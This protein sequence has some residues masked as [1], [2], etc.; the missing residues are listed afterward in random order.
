MTE[1]QARTLGRA[2]YAVAAL[3]I[4]S[5]LVDLLGTVLP[6]RFGEVAWRFGTYGLLT[7]AL[8]TPTLG[9]ALLVATGLLRGRR[10]LVRI[11]AVVLT[12]IAVVLVAGLALFALD[13]IQLRGAVGA[14]VRG[15]YDAAAG[16]AMIHAALDVVVLGLLAEASYVASR[17]VNRAAPRAPERVGLVVQLQDDGK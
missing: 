5:P 15:S 11:A 4:V 6:P 16:K 2:G 8:V 7:N 17:G 13:Y 3:L 10:V 14:A 9:L 1:F 12:L